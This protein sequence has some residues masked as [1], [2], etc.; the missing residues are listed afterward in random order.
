VKD[1][2]RVIPLPAPGTNPFTQT[3]NRAGFPLNG[4]VD[5]VYV[6]EG[7]V[8]QGYPVDPD[9]EV[10]GFQETF[11]RYRLS[12]PGWFVNESDSGPGGAADPGR[13]LRWAKES[14]QW[15]LALRADNDDDCDDDRRR[16]R[17]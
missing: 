16:R 14:A 10:I 9:P 17:W 11:E 5:V 3:R 6:G 1:A 4:G 15:M 13:S 7:S 8:G 2:D 12:S